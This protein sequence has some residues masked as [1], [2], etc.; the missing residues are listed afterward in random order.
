MR[1]LHYHEDVHKLHVNTLPERAYFI[2]YSSRRLAI[3]GDREKSDRFLSLNGVWSF[4]YFD[5]FEDLP[6]EF[7]AEK[8]VHDEIVVPSVWQTQGYD[9]HQYTN[10]RYPFPF[11]PPYVPVDNPCGLYV[12]TFEYQPRYAG[13]RTLC[14]EG[15][16][17]CFY[18][19][20]NGE[21][22]G[23]SQVSHSMSEFDVTPFVQEGSN[24]IAVLV[25]KWCDGSY[26]EDQDKF[27]MSGI[28]RDVYLLERTGVGIRD[29]FVHT[30]LSNHYSNARVQVDL[31]LDSDAVVEYRFYDADTNELCGTAA[32]GHCFIGANGHP[33]SLKKHL[34]DVF[35]LYHRLVWKPEE[36]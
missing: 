9:R 23:Y 26:F 20:I 17:S 31:Q 18:V 10:V 2:P 30:E 16:D 29:Y 13:R 7:S 5:S 12:R 24:T 1:K 4:A 8:L 28:F 14:F 15:V 22:V 6:A 3:E 33:L 34:P 25:L 35:E 32:S 36:T 21:F 19:W 11:D 27:R